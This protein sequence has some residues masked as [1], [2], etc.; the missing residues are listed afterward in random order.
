MRTISQPWLFALVLV[1]LGG[2][3]SVGDGPTYAEAR[4]TTP[5]TNKATVYVYRKYAEPTVWPVTIYFGNREVAAL[6]QGSF[7][8]T[9]IA[10]GKHQV[11]GVWPGFSGQQDASIEI[12]VKPATTYYLEVTGISRGLPGSGGGVAASLFPL[13]MGSGIN[14]VSPQA[15][16]ATL[17]SCCTFRKPTAS[18]Y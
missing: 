13:R 5:T 16:E 3:A 1:C 17:A 12:E 4:S 9:N 11:R 6:N 10:P 7:T 14:E 2:C 15:A 18:D 8:W